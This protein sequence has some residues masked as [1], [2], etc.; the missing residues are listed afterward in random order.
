MANDQQ[1]REAQSLITAGNVL[2]VW[3]QRDQARQKYRQAMEL[4]EDEPNFRDALA[5]ELALPE[6]LPGDCRCGCC[7]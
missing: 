5:R 3:N 1:I 2:K 6:C 7:M 4:V